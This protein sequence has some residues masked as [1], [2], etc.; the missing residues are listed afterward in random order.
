MEANHYLE[1]P[2]AALLI[3]TQ[4][5]TS[6]FTVAGTEL[7]L[8]LVLLASESELSLAPWKEVSIQT[9]CSVPSLATLRG[10]ASTP[11]KPGHPSVSEGDGFDLDFRAIILAVV[12]MAQREEKAGG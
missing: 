5:T 10:L 7:L 11:M 9:S 2:K 8:A 3:V 1:H 6:A 4:L 12:R